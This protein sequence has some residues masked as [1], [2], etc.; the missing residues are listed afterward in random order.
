MGLWA[1]LTQPVGLV[2]RSQEI[3]F[4]FTRY[5][6]A[7]SLGALGWEA[8][9]QGLRFVGVPAGKPQGFDA[10]FGRNLAVTF[11]KLGPTFIKLGQVLASRPD[12]VGEAVAEELRVLFDRVTPVSF[13]EIER[14]LKREFGAKKYAKAFRAVDPESLA[15]A[16]ISQTHKALLADGTPVILKVQKPGVDRRVRQDLQLLAGFVAPLDKVYPQLQLKMVFADF[17]RATL[18]EIDY[19]QEAANIDKFRRNYRKIFSAAN[20]VFPKYYPNLLTQ[21]V[22]A[23]EPMRGHSVG[24]LKKGSTVARA[25]AEQSLAALFEQIFDHG[26]FHA[27]PHAGNLFFQQDTGQVGFI[28]MG[29]VGQLQPTD[30]KRFLKVILAVLKRDRSKLARSLY[31]LGTPSKKTRYDA[32]EKDVDAMIDEHAGKGAQISLEKLVGQ[33]LAVARKNGLYVP[34]RYVLLLRSCLVMEG[35]AKGLDPDISVARV[36]TPIVARSLARSYNPLRFLQRK[37]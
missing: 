24:A 20:A 37:P 10:A 28:D 14:I 3:A 22:I 30:K 2:F 34:N 25:A 5:G 11:T 31:D 19:K 26:F 6:L 17:E 32:F 29:L 15:S 18:A 23:L 27:D 33:L 35:V 36:A 21:H 12:L 4:A 8:G 9:K 13:S 1:K 16:S 7:G